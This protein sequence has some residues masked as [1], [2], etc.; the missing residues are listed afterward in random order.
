MPTALIESLPRK[1][2]RDRVPLS[3]RDNTSTGEPV[4]NM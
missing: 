3:V 4:I 1:V 2:H